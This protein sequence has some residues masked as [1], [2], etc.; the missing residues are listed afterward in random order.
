[1]T[2]LSRRAL[3]KGSVATVAL[4]MTQRPLSVFGFD[5]PEPDEELVKFLPDQM[6]PKDRTML[7][8]DELTS[9]IT[10]NDQIFNVAHYGYPEVNVADW[11][12]EVGG[13]VKHPLTLTL[14]ELKS[15]RHKTV[16]ATLECSGNGS[17]PGFMGAIANAR[18]TG[19]SLRSLLKHAGLRDRAREVVFFGLDQ[20]T[21]NVRS[22]D[23]NMH[24]SR[25]L[26]LEDAI[27]DDVILCW[28]VNG[29]P[30]SPKNGAPV[31]LVVPGWFG[32]A[33]TKWITRIEV[34]DRRFM[35]KYMGREYVTIRGEEV[36]GKMLWKETQVGLIDTK[37]IVA[38]VTRRKDGALRITGAAWT[39][40]TPLDKVVLQIDDGDWQQVEL[41]RHHRH[42]KHSWT[43]W[44]FIWENP[45]AGEHKLVS[46]ATDKDGRVQP[47]LTDPEIKNKRTYWEANQQFP[48]KIRI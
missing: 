23:F 47:T 44:S 15:R 30:L 45:P 41:D 26:A 42:D 19:T 32:I 2:P 18:W 6:I 27:A 40:G 43:F 5:A 34:L 36:D 10:P 13:W 20:K 16:T 12:L 31:R 4:A 17:N 28:E 37:S 3:L 22:Q 29:E 33:W 1:M 46:R 35:S 14:D 24:F 38:R 39:D 25:S 7:K 48:R 21:E 11:K 9:W 8:W